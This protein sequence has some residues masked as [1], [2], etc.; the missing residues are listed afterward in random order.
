MP[1][2]EQPRTIAFGWN[3]EMNILDVKAMLDIDRYRKIDVNATRSVEV[4]PD[5]HAMAAANNTHFLTQCVRM[6]SAVNF[7][8]RD[9]GRIYLR[10][11]GGRPIWRDAEILAKAMLDAET[12]AGILAVAPDALDAIQAGGNG[13]Q[14]SV[15]AGNTDA[16]LARDG[17]HQ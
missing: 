11:E 4:Y 6:L 10:L 8:D 3:G 7:A 2:G 15:E 16:E 13:R 9:T 14:R 12:R 17:I 5:G 1:F